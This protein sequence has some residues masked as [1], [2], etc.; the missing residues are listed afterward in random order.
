MAMDATKTSLTLPIRYH[1]EI[2]LRNTRW[3]AKR[4]A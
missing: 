2:Y 3:C 1:A 4:K